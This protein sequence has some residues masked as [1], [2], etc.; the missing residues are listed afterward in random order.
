MILVNGRKE[1]TKGWRGLSRPWRCNIA[2][3]IIGIRENSMRQHNLSASLLG[4]A[5][6][7]FMLAASV[8][9]HAGEKSAAG[10]LNSFG[11]T[12]AVLDGS[13]GA[14]FGMDIKVN[15]PTGNVPVV[16]KPESVSTSTS[17][18]GGYIVG[19]SITTAQGTSTPSNNT[20][21]SGKKG[22]ESAN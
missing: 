20:G 17:T 1:L 6:I 18:A 21:K 14:C 2:V 4:F 10:R 5:V 3:I 7:F 19:G 9:A 12:G 13:D 16:G 22:S 11:N 8:P 15:K